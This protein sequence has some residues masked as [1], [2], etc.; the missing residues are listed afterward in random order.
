M[1]EAERRG[2]SLQVFLTEVLERE[3]ASAQNLAWIRELRQRSGAGA[4]EVDVVQLIGEQRRQRT[5]EIL[6]TAGY[7]D[8][9]VG[10]G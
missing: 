4:S 8:V 1:A 10:A 3:A 6:D 2:Q 5:R 7:A 9:P